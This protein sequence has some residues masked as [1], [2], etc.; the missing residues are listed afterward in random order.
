[1]MKGQITMPN[2]RFFR[3]GGNYRGL[4]AALTSF[5]CVH[6][7]NAAGV[8]QVPSET[9]PT[10]ESALS[11]A[12]SGDIVELSSGSYMLQNYEGITVPSGVTLK[13]LG[14]S[15]ADTVIKAYSENEAD[16]KSAS[17]VSVSHGILKNLTFEGARSHEEE[18]LI[19]R[20]LIA[21]D[22]SLISDCI[23]TDAKIT[24]KGAFCGGVAFISNSKIERTII[25][26]T[27]TENGSLSSQICCLENSEMVDCL[28]ENNS[29]RLVA[30]G[31]VQMS[32]TSVL[33]NTTVR[34]NIL[35]QSGKWD[36]STP[37][38][39]VQTAGA[40]IDGCIIEE[41]YAVK[42]PTSGV[43]SNFYKAAGG[44]VLNNQATVVNS[45]IRNN[46]VEDG[47]VGGVLVRYGA[48][49]LKNLLI[50]G[51]Q[52]LNPHTSETHY[53]RYVGGLRFASI[54]ANNTFEN[55]K[56]Y[57][58]TVSGNIVGGISETGEEVP[59]FLSHGV[60]YQNY[61]SY[62]YNCIFYGN[63]TLPSSV[64][65]N[66]CSRSLKYNCCMQDPFFVNSAK[67]DYRLMANSPCID[68]GNE[69]SGVPNADL[70]GVPRPYGKG[71]D[72][73]CYEWVKPLGLRVIIR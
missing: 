42:S 28:V 63:G 47:G 25:R 16:T 60:H 15:P 71:I 14:D 6:S 45:I 69:D 4:I 50:V 55:T 29:A 7:A 53:E 13:G 59:M 26:N 21:T 22:E 2:H 20:S 65:Y 73:G 1:M 46:R 67:G 10:I 39:R 68:A 32:G 24:G 41:N 38:V 35:M 37:G 30:A 3:G 43:L 33:K 18:T 51:N 23:F 70:K 58:C 5:Y 52:I 44:L 40:L 57:N 61:K 19:Y 72:I 8:L 27:K 49:V 48:S 31:M 64:N 66:D 54:N 9:Y 62:T 12:A 56:I 11:V 36:W 34:K 17:L